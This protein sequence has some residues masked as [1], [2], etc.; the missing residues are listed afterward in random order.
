MSEY[1]HSFNLTGFGNH[2]MIDLYANRLAIFVNLFYEMIE[3]YNEKEEI[4]LALGV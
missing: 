2:K 4:K 1:N 3:G